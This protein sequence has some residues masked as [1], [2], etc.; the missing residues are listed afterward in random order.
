MSIVLVFSYASADTLL[1]SNQYDIFKGV[2]MGMSIKDTEMKL[3]TPST[4]FDDCLVYD[5]KIDTLRDCSLYCYYFKNGERSANGG[6]TYFWMNSPSF[7]D[8]TMSNVNAILDDLTRKYGAPDVEAIFYCP[9]FYEGNTNDAKIDTYTPFNVSRCTQ[10]MDYYVTSVH[11]GNECFYL[12]QWQVEC[13]DG[14][15]VID[16]GFFDRNSSHDFQLD[17]TFLSTQEVKECRTIK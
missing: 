8:V 2:T 11:I 12:W 3:G 16:F 9:K 6:L 17:Y 10:N 1:K 7:K 4:S 14:M 13:S 5:V 15:I